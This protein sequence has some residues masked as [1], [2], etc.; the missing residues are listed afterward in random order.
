MKRPAWN[1]SPPRDAHE[2]RTRILEATMRGIDTRGARRTN[3]STVAEALG[4]TRQTVYRHFLSTEELFTAVG[5]AA[6]DHYVNQLLAHL[7]DT[8][9]P[10]EFVVEAVAY[11][12]ERLPHDRYLTVLLAAGRPS[13]FSRRAMTEQ[14]LEVCRAVLERSPVDWARRGYGDAEL[15]EL[16]EFVVRLLLSFIA[17]PR[18]SERDSAELRRFLRR[19]VAPALREPAGASDRTAA[20]T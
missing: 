17:D 6:L 8:D 4:V 3:L 7:G 15:I 2:A 18:P 14:S 19:W 20:G 1:G 12:I 9:D 10:A 16:S 11:T 5:F 13:A